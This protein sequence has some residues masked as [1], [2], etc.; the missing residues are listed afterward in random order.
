MAREKYNESKKY[1]KKVLMIKHS[2]LGNKSAAAATT[3]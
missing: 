2:T 3:V 1:N